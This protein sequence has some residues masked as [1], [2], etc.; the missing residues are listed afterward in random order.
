MY[1]LACTY[2]AVLSMYTSSVDYRIRLHRT[3][4]DQ[5]SLNKRR[6]HQPRTACIPVLN[7]AYTSSRKCLTYTMLKENP[8]FHAAAVQSAK[9][10]LSDTAIRENDTYDTISHKI[11]RYDT[12]RSA[13]ASPY[14]SIYGRRLEDTDSCR[15][16][17]LRSVRHTSNGESET[18]QG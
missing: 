16:V 5:I 15:P 12:I 2:S 14:V 10:V 3:T 1:T 7:H 18:H 9:R 11:S 4:S 13:S 8:L 17:W 6:L